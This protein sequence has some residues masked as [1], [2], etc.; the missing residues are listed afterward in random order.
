M[1]TRK[2]WIVALALT[3]C[4]FS[5]VLS[6][7]AQTS[8]ATLRGTIH[9]EQG[10]VLPGVTVTARQ[11]E[12]NTARNTVSNESGQYYLPNLPAGSYELTA[13]L[14]GFTPLKQTDIRL[15][16]G[17][18]FTMNLVLKVG[19]VQEAIT[20]SGKAALVET[21][22]TLGTMI[23]KKDIDDLPTVAR[24]FASL[25]RLAPGTT[26]SNYSG[27]NLGTGVSFGGQRQ[28][29]NN[30][31][32]DGTSNLMQFYGRQANTFPQ[33]WIQEFQVLT[34]SFS[35]EFGQASG[36][37]LNVITRSGANTV[38]GRGYGFFRDAK[39][40]SP[41]YAGRFVSGQ[42]TYL[43]STPPFSQK[44]LGGFL[45]G[46]IAKDRLF[47]FTGLEYMKRNDSTVLGISDYWRNR[48]VQTLIPGGHHEKDFVIKPDW[49]L[50]EKHRVSFRYNSSWW[51]DQNVSLGGSAN[52]TIDTRYT[53]NG[54]LWNVMGNI[55][56]TLGNQSFNEAKVYYGVNKPLIGCN[57]AGGLGGLA[58]LQADG[59]MG[60]N[61]KFAQRTYPGANFGCTGFTG[62]EGE[63]NLYLIDNFSFVKGRHQVKLGGQAARNTLYMDVE[64]SHKGRWGFPADIAFDINNP[65]S[66]PDTFSGNISLYGAGVA[67]HTAWSPGLFAQ[68]TWQVNNS[69]TLN[70]GV[71]YDVDYTFLA[72][73]EYVDA[74]NQRIVARFGGAPPAQKINLDAN[75]VAPRLGFVW[76]PTADRRTTVRAS[77]GLFY[78][79]NH[80]NYSDIWINETLQSLQ[81]ISFNAND[82]ATNPFWP[83]RAALRAFLARNFPAYPDLSLAPVQKENELGLDP[84]V[85]VPYT[86]QYAVGVTHSFEWGLDVQADYVHSAGYDMII[87]GNRNWQQV[88]GVWVPLDPRFASI[89]LYWNA[90]RITY[91][92]L[93]TRAQYRRG[94][95]TVGLSYTLART[96]SNT[97]AGITGG[98]A[99]WPFDLSVDYGPDN[100]D[101]RHNLVV[102]TSYIFPLDIQLAAI[103]IYRSALP[104][105]VSTR[106]NTTNLP[107]IPRPEPRNSRR[108]D[109]EKTVDLR[110]SK[111]FKFGRYGASVFWEMFNAPNFDNFL[112]YAGSL[113]SSTFGLPGSALPK[114]Q[115][116]LG[117]KLDF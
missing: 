13:E 106:F 23:E 54:P 48:G 81:R 10:G 107:Y 77:F 103:G 58:L 86:A 12:T 64:A 15:G 29:Q 20:V 47:F 34:N 52:D 88:N 73:N 87:G 57:M 53:F 30:I 98:S 37:V 89:N 46:P 117:F 85:K 42:P 104:W 25:A 108:G 56:S 6:A 3:L 59:K 94:T 4:V 82:A 97:T 90:G 61:G 80:Y 115:Q 60:Q 44:R 51:E 36:G 101:R 79:Q 105:S 78:D 55:A 75:N 22:S 70:L 113:Q 16:V 8:M 40:D 96:M 83:D 93:Q 2:V 67:T 84:N 31:I 21:Q 63:A 14:A 33:D 116:Q 111:I 69:L 68:D 17:Q 72:G 99:T 102:N 45:G 65:A 26:A 35:A 24:D 9:D 66:Y 110:V 76:V 28:Y 5:L 1:A 50:S 38:S 100:A 49:N 18:D 62:L 32:V 19:G 41:P 43:S 95:A 92:G 91:N 39:F 74:Y 27:T 112:S 7:S 11:I 71:R 114:R 109:S